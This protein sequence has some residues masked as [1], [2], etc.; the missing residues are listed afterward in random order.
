[1]TI[2]DQAA[3]LETVSAK[4]SWVKP[5]IVTFTPAV[6]AQG[7]TGGPTTDSGNPNVS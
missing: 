7:G 2:N 6:E 4:S 5:E 1:M 3:S